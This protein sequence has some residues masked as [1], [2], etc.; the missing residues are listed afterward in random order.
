MTS[1]S[2]PNQSHQQMAVTLALG[3]NMNNR[4]ANLQEAIKHIP[5]TEIR[6]SKIYQ[7]PAWLPPDAPANWNKSFLNMAIVGN[8]ATTSA[9]D[10]LITIQEIEQKLGRP[11]NH[12][13]WS[14]RTIDI[15]IIFW[16][17]CTINKPHLT[18][19]HIDAYNRPFVMRPLND[20]MPEFYPPNSNKTIAE[21][22]DLLTNQ[23]IMSTTYEV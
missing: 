20:I 2:T 17:N 8:T 18:I 11:S 5:L 4:L 13:R 9:E 3:S 1:N 14:P 21:I 6:C 7:T 23:Q 19:P 22:T 12:Q 16:G 15:D 10:F